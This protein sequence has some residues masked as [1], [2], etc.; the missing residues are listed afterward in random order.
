MAALL[1]QQSVVLDTP[2][3]RGEDPFFVR[4]AQIQVAAVDVAVARTPISSPQKARPMRIEREENLITPW[5]DP[6]LTEIPKRNN[7]V[8]NR[9]QR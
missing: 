1:C 5:I 7:Q 4:A 3:S 6:W 2:V 8:V 9:V